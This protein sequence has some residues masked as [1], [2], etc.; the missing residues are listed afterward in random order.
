MRQ[1]PT[2]Q[3]R[4]CRAESLFVFESREKGVITTLA[5]GR[6]PYTLVTSPHT[7]HPTVGKLDHEEVL[8]CL[9]A[10]QL[11]SDSVFQFY[12]ETVRRKFSKDS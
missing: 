10:A 12:R 5:Q 11:A 6:Q 1:C 2:R 4:G 3:L 9:S 8:Q 7:S